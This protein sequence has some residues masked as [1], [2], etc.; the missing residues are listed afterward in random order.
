MSGRGQAKPRIAVRIVDPA[1]PRTLPKACAVAETAARAALDAHRPKTRAAMEISIALADDALLARLN[2][3]W[4]GRDGATNVLSFPGEAAGGGLREDAQ[5]GGP[6]V[7]LGD[8]VLARETVAAEAAAQQ[9]TLAAHA[10]HL[11]VHG[12]LHLLGHD[13]DG[14]AAAG[15]M[16]GL[17]TRIL[18]TL[19]IGDPYAAPCPA[20][21][22]PAT[23]GAR[24]RE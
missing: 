23:A 17:E 20:E 13:H 21:L 19:G 4:R 1:W 9:K 10:S 14:E 24:G 2:R 6:P 8:V 16:E 11:V 22:A 3:D 15:A 5:P 7:M 12:V 18:A